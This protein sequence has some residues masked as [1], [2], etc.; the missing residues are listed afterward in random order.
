[1]KSKKGELMKFIAI[2]LLTVSL[3]INAQES[4]QNPEKDSKFLELK[5]D[6]PELQLE[7]DKLKKQFDSDLNE[8]KSEFKEQKKSL[9]KSYKGRLKELRKSFKKQKIKKR[10]KKD[11]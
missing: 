3:T 9:R 4:K 6:D 8:L 11:N 5:V 1:M 7:I 2:T 10:N